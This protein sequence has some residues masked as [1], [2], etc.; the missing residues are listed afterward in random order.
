MSVIIPYYT[1]Y[2]STGAIFLP[3]TVVPWRPRCPSIRPR[4]WPTRRR[5][6][7]HGTLS[8][9][10]PFGKFLYRPYKMGYNPKNPHENTINTMGTLLGVHPIVPWLNNI[11]LEACTR[12]HLQYIMCEW[13]KWMR[14]ILKINEQWQISV[15]IWWL[16]LINQTRPKHHMI[17]GGLY[18]AYKDPPL[19]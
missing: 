12:M 13:D 2:L 5:C 3:S 14:W 10:T 15:G 4:I 18:V 9:G 17:E 8:H 7:D 1:V 6:K 16:F 19:A 11:C